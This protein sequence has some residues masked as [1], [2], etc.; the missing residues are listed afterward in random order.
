MRDDF[1]A[2]VKRITAQ[3]AG[4]RCSN[5]T[6][7]A[8]TSGPQK[9]PTKAVNLGVAAHITAASPGGPRYQPSASPQERSSPENG[10]WLC[11][12]CAK[13]IDNDVARF[14]EPLLRHWKK[15]AEDRATQELGRQS[16]FD[17]S[18]APFLEIAPSELGISAALLPE[19][20]SSG[21]IRQFLSLFPEESRSA[22]QVELLGSGG[23]A[24]GQRYGIIGAGTNHGWDWSVGLF[25][26]GE[27]GWERVA[28]IHLED[29]KAW[30]PEAVYIPG[31]PGAL[32]LTHVHG[33]GTGVFRR[34]TSWYRI[35]K[36]EPSPFLS[37]PHEFYVVG[38]GMPFGRMLTSRAEIMPAELTDG[39]RLQLRFDVTYT[40]EGEGAVE[41]PEGEL[42]TYSEMLSLEWNDAAG[43]FVPRTTADD[44][45][46]IEEIWGEGTEG[47][48]K[49]NA[50]PLRQ[51][52]QQGTPSQRRFIQEHFSL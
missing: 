8:R 25:T 37:H 13:L 30:T 6:C 3:R 40:M 33:Y 27:F 42:L 19:P 32:V 43:L 24:M 29:Q 5:P 17:R 48:S 47:F 14:T 12:T 45:A 44:F 11:Q 50:E 9:D 20:L 26:G 28:N 15:I 36:G 16:P 10:I 4:H 38:W 31:T 34:S 39:A 18:G 22:E 21:A 52:A 51:L 49:R 1:P 35:A 7:G 23:G 41:G 2:S 46:R